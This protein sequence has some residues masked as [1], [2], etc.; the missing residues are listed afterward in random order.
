VQNLLLLNTKWTAKQQQHFHIKKHKSYSTL[1]ELYYNRRNLQK[2]S[3]LTK[4]QKL[5][6]DKWWLKGRGTSRGVQYIK[7]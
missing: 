7:T 4:T 6:N 5:L 2:H 1:N 3:A